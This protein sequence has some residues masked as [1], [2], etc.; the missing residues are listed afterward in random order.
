VLRHGLLIAP[1]EQS[2]PKARKLLLYSARNSAKTGTLESRLQD[3]QLV[4][5]ATEEFYSENSAAMASGADVLSTLCE[6]MQVLCCTTRDQADPKQLEDNLILHWSVFS[7][8]L[9][10]RFLAASTWDTCKPRKKK[11]LLESKCSVVVSDMI[12]KLL[13]ECVITME[14]VT[15]QK[16]NVMGGLNTGGQLMKMASFEK[17]GPLFSLTRPFFRQLLGK[18]HACLDLEILLKTLLF[19]FRCV[20]TCFFDAS[21]PKPA[22]QP[23]TLPSSVSRAHPL[24]SSRQRGKSVICFAASS[25]FLSFWCGKFWSRLVACFY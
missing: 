15:K 25:W 18:L 8:E 13:E 5:S 21:T 12:L 24:V 10:S 1:V 9:N 11:K 2:F 23:S 16:E 7:H 19:F 6:C 22:G 20:S 4:L 17:D 14:S 3:L